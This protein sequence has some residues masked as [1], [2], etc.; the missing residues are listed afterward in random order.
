MSR[1]TGSC[2]PRAFGDTVSLHENSTH[3]LISFHLARSSSREIISFS[4]HSISFHLVESRALRI[5]IQIAIASNR[6]IADS[7]RFISRDLVSSREIYAISSSREIISYYLVFIFGNPYI[8]KG[9]FS[10]RC[11]QLP[12][13]LSKMPATS[14]EEDLLS[15]MQKIDSND[16]VAACANCGKE[17]SDMNICNKCKEATYC[18]A[19]CKKKHRSKHKKQ[20]ERRAAELHDEALFREPPPAHGECPICFLLLPTMDSGGNYM[21]CCG[22]TICSG[23]FHADVFD[24]LGNTIADEKCP[25][26]RTPKASSDEEMIE[27]LTKRMEV[28][29][30]YAFFLMGCHY[31]L[32]RHGLPQ[33]SA[34][35]MELWH[36]AGKFGYNNIGSAYVLGNG[37]ERDEKMAEHYYE[38]AAMEGYVTARRNLGVDEYEAGNYERALKHFMI[39]VRGGDTDSVKAIQQLYM[40]GHVTKDQYANALRSHLAYLNE[41]KSDQRDKAAAFS[42]GCSYY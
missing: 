34:K 5:A 24:N 8:A 20:C 2:G 42:D 17:G 27:R 37:V 36:K 40:D 39:A 33:D 18:N 23:C 30:A 25:F 38:L 9:Q 35:A 11:P 12:D 41:I 19:A 4:S 7:S 3:A 22:K 29:D 6:E 26:C 1:T 14:N 21:T 10:G 15:E 28:G 32:G 16:E 13:E 31:Y